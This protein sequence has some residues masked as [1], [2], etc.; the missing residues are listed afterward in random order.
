[1][2]EGQARGGATRAP[3]GEDGCVGRPFLL[4]YLR[5][6]SWQRRGGGGGA[7]VDCRRWGQDTDARGR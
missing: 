7:E 5:P 4:I 2:V 3:R 6:S 1:M